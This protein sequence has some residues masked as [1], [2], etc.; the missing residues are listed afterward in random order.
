MTM[1]KK[2]LVHEF[3]GPVSFDA[4]VSLIACDEVRHALQNVKL[5]GESW[6]P[7]L[8][9]E[10]R[11]RVGDRL[12][13]INDDRPGIGLNSEKLPNIDWCKFPGG[14]VELKIMKV[15]GDHTSGVEKVLTRH[16]S[17]FEISR[18]PI[19]V[20]QFQAFVSDCFH[21]GKWISPLE[22]PFEL[23][24]NN[25]IPNHDVTHRANQAAY[26]IS[27]LH[28][29]AFCQWLG[30]RLN[31]NIQIPSEF[32]W[33]GAAN[34]GDMKR[35]YP[36]GS[37]WSSRKANTFENDLG[38]QVS[39]GL[40]PMGRSPIGCEDLAGNIWEW[41]RNSFDHPESEQ[42][43]YDPKTLRT[44]RGGSWDYLRV[45]TECDFRLRPRPN[46]RYHNVGFRIVRYGVC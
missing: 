14:E 34:G 22:L 31:T 26:G 33:Q 17:S 4:L 32:E 24:L 21:N 38:R 1:L 9:H 20:K 19:T 40:Y 18:F 15:A 43:P 42:H 27:Y 13:L 35:K 45:A 39:V 16:I 12:A 41:C 23:E 7:P 10:K 46:L 28:A 37:R 11:A 44:L 3:L 29:L 6:H 2:S 36:W 5:Y 25:P 30:H 8:N